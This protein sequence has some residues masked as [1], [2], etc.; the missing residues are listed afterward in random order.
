MGAARMTVE[1]IIRQETGYSGAFNQS[2]RLD[3]LV[4]DSLEFL[5]LVLAIENAF[6]FKVPDKKYTEVQTVGDLCSLVPDFVPN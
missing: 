3:S 4:A 2:T 6:H 5:S 1:E